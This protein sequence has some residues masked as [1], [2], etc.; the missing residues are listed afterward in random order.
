MKLKVIILS[1]FLF[2]GVMSAQD[3]TYFMDQR[4]LQNDGF[5]RKE[6]ADQG[7]MISEMA[8]PAGGSEFTIWAR[9]DRGNQ[10][11]IMHQVGVDTVGAYLP[12]GTLSITTPDP[13]SGGIPRTRVDQGFTLHGD[14]GGLKGSDPSTPLA[15]QKVLLDHRVELFDYQDETLTSLSDSELF[16]QSFVEKNGKIEEPYLGNLP[17]NDVYTESGIETFKLYAL[18]DG[19]IAQMELAEAQVQ[20]WP[21]A[22]CNVSGLDSGVTY[23]TIPDITFDL[24]NLYPK[25]ET[26]LRYY[27]GSQSIESTGTR[28]LDV[29]ILVD[30]NVPRDGSLVLESPERFFDQA[31]VWTI[32]VLTDT[33]FGTERLEFLELNVDSDLEIRGGLNFLK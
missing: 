6:V 21:L 3:W 26:Y 8:I 18:P 14:V 20:I 24:K 16:E 13:Y 17:G 23:Q 22:E 7:D 19:Q 27:A 12:T 29:Q 11:P 32:E 1:N 28:I 15:A 2:L 33:P 30:Q 10:A 4:N 31:G 5:I 25:S 9:E